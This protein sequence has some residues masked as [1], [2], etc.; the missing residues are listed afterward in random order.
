MQ[1]VLHMLTKR[2]TDTPLS[3]RGDKLVFT[4]ALVLLALLLGGVL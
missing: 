1:G 3:N 4:F 2:T